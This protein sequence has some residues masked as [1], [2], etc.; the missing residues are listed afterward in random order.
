MSEALDLTAFAGQTV[1]IKFLSYIPQPLTGPG[2]MQIDNV[3][4]LATDGEPPVITLT[5]DNPQEI[6]V[7]S[8]Y[9]ELGATVTDNVDEGLEAVI[10]AS[11]VN[12]F[13]VGLYD[14]TYNAMDSSG[15]GADQVVRTVE[16][17]DTEAPV[18][19]LVGGTVTVGLGSTYVDAGASAVDNYDTGLVVVID[20][21]A[22]NT[23]ELG[24][25]DVYFDVS[26][27]SGNEAI[28]VVRTV[29]VV[30][31]T[32]PVVTLVG[33]TQIIE[34]PDPYVELG[35]TVTDNSDDEIE[36][37]I[38][39]SAVD[40]GT[41]G[42][43]LVTYDASDSSG[44][45]AEQVVRTVRVVD[46]T[47][48]V[49]SLDGDDPQ[50]IEVYSPYVEAGATA[51]DNHDTG[52]TVTVDS[53]AVDTDTVGDYTVTYDVTDA[54]GNVAAQVSRTVSVVDTTIPVISLIGDA[55]VTI[56]VGTTYVDAGATVTDNY[57][58][59]LTVTP[60]TSGVD[61]STV[62]I[63][64]V[65]FDVTDSNGNDAVQVTRTVNVEDTGS[66][67]ITLTGE[68]DVTIEVGSTYVDDG[69]TASDIGDG[70]LTSEIVTV[71]PVDDDTVDVY[72]V[73]YNVS[74]SSGNAAAE[75]TRT[76]RVVDTT[77]PVITLTGD[78]EVTIEVGTT[79]EDDGATADDNYDGDI[80]G[81]IVTDNPVDDSVVGQYT[82]TY[83]V[84]DA[85][86]NDAVQ[87][88]RT[89]NVVD[90]TVP[91]ITLDGDDPQVIEVYSAYVEAG[92]SATDN[93][94]V[95][96]TVTPDASSVD[97]STV[98]E[99]T[100]YYNATDA[101]GNDAA[102]VTRTVSV[103]DTTI[104][105]IT[106][107]GGQPDGRQLIGVFYDYVELGA[108][109]TDNY[110][111]GLVAVIDASAVN[112]DVVGEYPVTYNVT[113]SNGNDAVEVI[114]TVEIV[115]DG[116][117]VITL[118]GDAEVTIEVGTGYADAGAV[119]NDVADG[120]L[121]TEILTVD[122][123]D[124]D[125]V[126]IYTVTYD[127]TDEDSNEAIQATRTVN[128]VDTTAPVIA[129]LGDD[130]QEVEVN[131]AY[132]EAGASVSDN[133]D[134]GLVSAVDASD[135]DTSTVGEYTVYYDVTDANGNDAV[136]VERTVNVVDTTAPVITLVGDDPQ[137]VEVNTAYVESGASVSD[138]YDSGLVADI[139]ASDVDT[140]VVGD[141]TVYY[142]VTDANGNDAVTVERTVSVVDTTAPVITLLGD[143]PQLVY[144][145]QPYVESGAS[146]SDNYDSG[147]VA[148]IDDSEV[149]TDV[150]GD[151][152]V[153]YDVADANGNDAVTVERTVS[154]VD[155]TAPVITLFG[156]DPQL[157]EVNTLYVE[158]G[159]SVSDNYDSGLVVDIDSSDVDMS[160]V[161]EYFV[162]YDATD[163]SGNDAD[164]VMRTVQVVD[165]T[166]PVITLLGDDPQL[167]Y[168]FLPYVE[169]GASVS[170]NY[171]LGLVADIDASDVDTDVVGEYTVYYDATDT[172]G[173]DAIQ[174]TRT[175]EVID[176]SVP[177]IT[178]IG[179]AEVT[180]SIR[181]LR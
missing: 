113:D 46:T 96:V 58:T 72:T 63:Y 130:P 30:D 22:V 161:G 170:D 48:P 143:D 26:D 136:T 117:P 131:T 181:P 92:A 99:Y 54:N 34:F 44:N 98:G 167:V 158:L 45:D 89:V 31:T 33:G 154:V 20:D 134:V 1:R 171:D 11:A 15:N 172:N 74:D 118:N 86:D 109:V 24:S 56:E 87:V 69:A 29:N 76:V 27:S 18:I 153:Y 83:D 175:V 115:D 102:E 173:N 50:V 141:Y 152:T 159:A 67:V 62:G 94:D 17:V 19:S 59:D 77:I 138:N 68:A 25:Y 66:P 149:D 71:N 112:T 120:D 110:D 142:D 155:T 180:W 13:V 135:V 73:T 176:V 36:I 100:V 132:V 139:D 165:T 38:D 119:A 8:S 10:D 148:D 75:V 125:T 12:T 133:Y 160:E 91:V 162:Y 23:S 41:L 108:S 40:A 78:A 150:V 116:L 81:A 156:D 28:T 60:D 35:A 145:F 88:T 166:A 82:V 95:T 114:R 137:E 146:V 124:A 168:V 164:Q 111:S 123:V 51:T 177:F 7:F 21:S 39:S 122:S 79:Y 53:T 5:G 32:I 151:Y 93:Y 6:E 70:D 169:S 90:T 107:L 140:S 129:L 65:T 2:S 147:L 16:V 43:Y 103:V 52:L 144:V 101:N 174:V 55:E 42:T 85:N 61:S 57:D 127:V 4:L 178:L 14:V 105:V 97:T 126:G 49:I 163:A 64:T 80:T 179:D 9:T 106:L 121:T 3:S 84:T 47:A 37:E 157:I 128:V 104:P